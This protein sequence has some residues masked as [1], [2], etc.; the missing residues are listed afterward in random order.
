MVLKIDA[1]QSKKIKIIIN[2]NKR[3]LGS[4]RWE[5]ISLSQIGLQ[6]NKDSV[7]VQQVYQNRCSLETK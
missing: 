5:S 1:K 3:L 2:V 7:N 4:I 6:E